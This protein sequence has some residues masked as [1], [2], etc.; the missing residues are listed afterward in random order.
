MATA[1]VMG[2]QVTKPSR[3]CVTTLPNRATPSTTATKIATPTSTDVAKT[4]TGFSILGW[5]GVV[6]GT[7]CQKQRPVSTPLNGRLDL[8]VSVIA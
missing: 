8:V 1:K 3:V 5:E 6:T 4:A 7:V 2:I